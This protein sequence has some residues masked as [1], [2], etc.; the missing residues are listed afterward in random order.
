ML[1]ISSS[2]FLESFYVR[3]QEI[4]MFNPNLF[5]LTFEGKLS[6]GLLN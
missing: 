2:L 5:F 1:K 3:K 4:F 6:L